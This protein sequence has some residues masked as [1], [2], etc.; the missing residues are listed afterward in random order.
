ME[1]PEIKRKKAEESQLTTETVGKVNFRERGVG[2]LI[3]V[4]SV[5][6]WRKNERD[7]S[8]LRCLRILCLFTVFEE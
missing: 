6:G 1:V 5:C 3:T 4:T 8:S 7:S 2:G